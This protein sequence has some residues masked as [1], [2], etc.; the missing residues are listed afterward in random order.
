M[1]AGCAQSVPQKVTVDL[2]PLRCPPIAGS[3]AR[4]LSQLPMAPP[5]GDMTKAG[6]QLWIDTLHSQIRAMS[7]AGERVVWQ[8][9]RCRSDAAKRAG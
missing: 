2:G 7:K 9:G 1:M 4:A 3:D 6:A 5:A 8:Y